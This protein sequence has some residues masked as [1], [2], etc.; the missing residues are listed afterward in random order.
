ML[1]QRRWQRLA[2]LEKYQRIVGCGGAIAAFKQIIQ[3][4]FDR[5]CPAYLPSFVCD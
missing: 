3:S 1:Q 4:L 2:D 5:H